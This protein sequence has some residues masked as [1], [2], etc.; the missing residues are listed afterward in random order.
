MIGVQ[1][2]IEV[3]LELKLKESRFKLLVFVTKIF[4]RLWS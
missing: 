2:P 4:A 3:S 1:Y